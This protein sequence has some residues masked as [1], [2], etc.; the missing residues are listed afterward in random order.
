MIQTSL[1]SR[2]GKYDTRY[3]ADTGLISK[4]S[5]ILITV[6]TSHRYSGQIYVLS[7]ARHG[8]IITSAPVPADT[9]MAA[10]ATKRVPVWELQ[11]KTSCK[12][13]CEDLSVIMA[14]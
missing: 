4:V 2:D 12:R 14:K 1:L 13:F 6:N 3:R 8:Q 5:V 7:C 11:S 10:P 9:N